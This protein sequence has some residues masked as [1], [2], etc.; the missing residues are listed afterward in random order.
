[1]LDFTRIDPRLFDDVRLVIEALA[2]AAT[3]ESECIMLVGAQCRDILHRALGH[4]SINR[5]TGDLDFGLALSDWE[6]FE[7]VD[8]AFERAGDSG[9]RYRICDVLVDVMP[10]G[11][12]IEDPTGIATPSPRGEELVVFGFEDVFERAFQLDLPGAEHHIRIPSP[13]GYAALKLRAWVDRSIY[14]EYKDAEDLA[15]VLSWYESSGTVQDRIYGESI[16]VADRYEYDIPLA[17][18]HLLGQDV[19]SQLKAVDADDLA[20]RLAQS[21]TRRLASALNGESWN[22]VRGFDLSLA[23]QAGLASGTSTTA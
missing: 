11:A 8:R 6:A 3:V 7:R 14:G 4:T 15:T 17:C 5:A 12:A 21:D 18:A 1:M 23:L 9:I 10:F 13:A 20:R 2:E 22:P 16:Q 19:R